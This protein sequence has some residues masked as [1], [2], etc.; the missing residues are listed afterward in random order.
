MSLPLRLLTEPIARDTLGHCFVLPSKNE[1]SVVLVISEYGLMAI[2]SNRKYDDSEL[3][4]LIECPITCL[5][6]FQIVFTVEGACWYMGVDKIT[7]ASIHDSRQ[8][9]RPSSSSQCSCNFQHNCVIPQRVVEGIERYYSRQVL[10]PAVRGF[11]SILGNIFSFNL[12]TIINNN[13]YRS[14]NAPQRS[15]SRGT[16]CIYLNFSRM[17]SMMALILCVLV[18]KTPEINAG[19][20]F[21]IMDAV[22]MLWT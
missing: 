2:A 17:L 10:E 22:S 11:L 20:N 4:Q 21:H 13:Y 14:K 15:N 6:V 19:C 7:V 18:G 3:C 5:P 9:L 12:R 1:D 16:I 8:T